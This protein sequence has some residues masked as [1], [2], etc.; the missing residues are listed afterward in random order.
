VGGEFGAEMAQEGQEEILIDLPGA[1]L[2]RVSEGGM[3]RC[4]GNPEVDQFALAGLESFVDFAEALG[5]A[6]LDTSGC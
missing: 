4:F 2:I 6:Q 1:V 5:L 3:F